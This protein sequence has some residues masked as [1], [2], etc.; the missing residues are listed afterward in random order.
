MKKSNIKIINLEKQCKIKK[1]SSFNEKE[2]L[3]YFDVISPSN[4][5]DEFSLNFREFELI[6]IFKEK[7]SFLKNN[8]KEKRKSFAIFQNKYSLLEELKN[9]LNFHYKII[10]FS[11][12]QRSLFKI[13]NFS[14]MNDFK[15][16]IFVINSLKFELNEENYVEYYFQLIDKVDFLYKKLINYI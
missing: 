12:L 4:K 6:E 15:N 7:I 13:Q 14:I 2:I 9:S 11:I 1:I 8:L 3:S 16:N 10:V 5:N